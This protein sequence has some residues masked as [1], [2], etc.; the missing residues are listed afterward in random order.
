MTTHKENI[1]RASDVGPS[2]D[3]LCYAKDVP[4]MFFVKFLN[5][6]VNTLFYL[7]L[8]LLAYNCEWCGGPRMW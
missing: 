1:A 3:Q 5:N 4:K 7:A 6:T 2:D 8:I